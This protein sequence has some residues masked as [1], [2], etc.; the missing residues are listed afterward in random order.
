MTDWGSKKTYK[1]SSVRLDMTPANTKFNFDGDEVSL[2]SYFKEKYGVYLDAK[3][4][5]LEIGQPNKK[6]IYLP[7][8]LCIIETLP[9]LLSRNKDLINQYKK[10][11]VEKL[12]AVKEV[13][14]EVASSSEL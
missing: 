13:M 9:D 8:Q 1:V 2:V 6:P 12:R 7:P 10:G 5:L 14:E 11:P 4:P 3:Q